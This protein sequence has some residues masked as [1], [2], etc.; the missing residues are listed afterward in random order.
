[1]T[2][3][4]LRLGVLIGDTLVEEQLLDGATPI[5]FG[6]SLR[7]TIS[8]PADGVP[9]EHVLFTCEGER[10]VLHVA[11]AAPQPLERGA[12]STGTENVHRSD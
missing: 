1:M 8:V 3:R 2:S 9:R 11:G 7:C 12:P 4:A 5:T 10:F 6:Q